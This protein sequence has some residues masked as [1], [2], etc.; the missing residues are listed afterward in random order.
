MLDFY[1]WVF[2]SMHFYEYIERH[3]NFHHF[4]SYNNNNIK[5]NIKT[6]RQY[7]SFMLFS[8]STKSEDRF[9]TLS[10]AFR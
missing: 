2:L 9:L 5:V 7:N 1:H 4:K 6:T 8:S 10:V 3:D